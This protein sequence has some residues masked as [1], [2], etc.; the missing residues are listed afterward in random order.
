VTKCQ[1]WQGPVL[2]T[3]YGRVQMRPRW[4]TAHVVAWE[5]VNGPVPRG[6]QVH[7]AC[8]TK[9]CVNVAHLILV[10]VAQHAMLHNPKRTTCKR[11]HLLTDENRKANGFTRAGT[12][13]WA[14]RTC[15]NEQQRERYHR[16][17]AV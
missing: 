2:D 13:K 8:G 11:G 10:T 17:R 1:L 14:C 7:H 6:Y 3:G 9:L 16:K 4:K 15:V 12:Q 5:K